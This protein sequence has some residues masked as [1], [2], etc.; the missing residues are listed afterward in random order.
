MRVYAEV[1]SEELTVR[2]FDPNKELIGELEEARWERTRREKIAGGLN[3]KRRQPY[4]ASE[5]SELIGYATPGLAD[6]LHRQNAAGL[7]GIHIEFEHEGRTHRGQGTFE[8]ML[9]GVEAGEDVPVFI[10]VPR[11]MR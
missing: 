7:F 6:R 10:S 5:S 4:V 8:I 11:A 9:D 2:V 3:P 1:L